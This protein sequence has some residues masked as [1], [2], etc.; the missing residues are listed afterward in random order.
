MTAPCSSRKARENARS[1]SSPDASK[2]EALALYA[3]R[4]LDLKAKLD[5]FANRL[6]S[7]N[8]KNREIDES[9]KT[10]SAE[11]EQPAVVGDIAALKSQFE[12]L[13]EAGAAKKAELTRGPQGRRRQGAGRTYRDCGEGRGSGQFPGRQHQLAF[14]RGQV[15]FAVPAVAGSPAQ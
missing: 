11:I 1:A 2:E 12:A 7:S 6:K 13:K 4:Y 10:L 14:H 5:L 8:V 9:I 3:R 15:P